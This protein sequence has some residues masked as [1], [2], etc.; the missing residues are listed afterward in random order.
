MLTPA[1]HRLIEIGAVDNSRK[2]IDAGLTVAGSVYGDAA[3]YRAVDGAPHVRLREPAHTHSNSVIAALTRFTAINSAL[4][5]DLLGQV[6]AETVL[7][8]DGRRRFVGGVGG[9]ND[10]MRAARLASGG[11]AIVALP[12]RQ[13]GEK[14]RRSERFVPRIVASLSGPATVAACD[15]DLVVTEHGVAHLRD[16]SADER[17][18]RLIAIAHPDDRDTLWSAAQRLGIMA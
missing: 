12:S 9:L 4:E 3:L 18:R 14:R 5:V 16:A 8:A 2:A 15:A 10:F 7:A 13:A 17:A 6:N 11:K 1:L